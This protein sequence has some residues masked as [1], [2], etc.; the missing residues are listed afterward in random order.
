MGIERH[1]QEKRRDWVLR[2]FRQFDAPVSVVLS[3]TTASIHG[4]DIA[5]FDCGAVTNALVQR[6]SLVAGAGV[7]DQQPGHHAIARGAR[8]R[9]HPRRSGDHDLRRHGLS[10]R[11]LPRQRRR[12]HPQAGGRARPCSS[13][14]T[15]EAFGAI[16]SRSHSPGAPAWRMPQRTLAETKRGYGRHPRR[17]GPHLHQPLRAPR[18]G[19][20]GGEGARVLERDRRHPVLRPGLDHR[21]DEGQR[22]ARPGRR[23]VQHRAEVVVHAQGGEGPPALPRGQRRRE[24]ARHLQG[25]GDHAARPAPPDRGLPDRLVQHAGA[26][27]LHLSARRVRARARGDGGRGQA[28][29]R[30]QADRQGQ[31]PRLGLR[32]LHPP[33]R[34][35]LHLRRGD[36]AAGVAGGQEGPSRA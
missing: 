11:Q 33:R 20:G 9:P 8:A 7:R 6:R 32:R 22:H 35:R 19:P 17:Q 36:G 27:L 24:R 5:P 12:L 16:E 2:G 1:D 34:R 3:P 26:R 23:R 29:L 14:S 31:R 15:P 21:P 25:P 4:G 28:G 10:R 18:L 13:A 30:G